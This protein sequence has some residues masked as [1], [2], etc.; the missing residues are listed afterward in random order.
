[1]MLVVRMGQDV[2][3]LKSL[4]GEAEDVVNNENG[5]FGRGRA[6]LI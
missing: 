2:S 6:G 4:R 1:M 5:G 3:A